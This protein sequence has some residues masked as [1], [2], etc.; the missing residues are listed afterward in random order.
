VLVG[1]IKRKVSVQSGLITIPYPW[2]RSRTYAPAQ[3][4]S[5]TNLMGEYNNDS[6]VFYS[7]R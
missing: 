5:L 2:G 6:Y 3:L 1:A 4:V 7:Q